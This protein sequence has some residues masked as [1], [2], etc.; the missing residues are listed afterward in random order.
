MRVA[1]E[2]L[3]KMCLLS[4]EEKPRSTSFV[5]VFFLSTGVNGLGQMYLISFLIVSHMMFIAQ[6]T[7]VSD[8]W[9]RPT[10]AVDRYGAFDARHSDAFGDSLLFFYA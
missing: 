2:P 3:G 4:R 5:H 9:V 8:A 6:K 1:V 10:F 7:R